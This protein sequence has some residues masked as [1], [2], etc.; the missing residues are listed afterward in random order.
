MEVFRS[1]AGA[2]AAGCVLS[3]LG[4]LGF[5][6]L[7]F[8]DRPG[9]EPHKQQGG[10]VALGGGIAVLLAVMAGLAAGGWRLPPGETGTRYLVVAMGAFALFVAGMIDDI[11]K[12]SPAAKVAIEAAVFLLVIIAGDVQ[13][14]LFV[15]NYAFS[16]VVTFMWMAMLTNAFNLID[17]HDGLA[18][19]VGAIGT[20]FLG[21]VC[22]MTGDTAAA[23]ALMALSGAMTGFVLVNFPPAHI[24]MGDAGTLPVGFLMAS[25]SILPSFYRAGIPG[26]HLAVLAPVFVFAVLLFDTSRVM[27]VRAMAGAN[28]FKADNRHFSHRLRNLGLSPTKVCCVHYLFA[29]VAAAPAVV[30]MEVGWLGAM[31]L[32]AQLFGTLVLILII[33]RAA[34]GKD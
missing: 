6:R 3:L 17:N 21:L 15:P 4:W 27:L 33:E 34:G 2:A 24:Y 20:F 19:G 7:G 30:L 28:P 5:R 14:T 11:R 23:A 25:M 13:I 12:L 26:T 1:F 32:L 22:V 9:T 8:L 31:V 16:V 10:A 18:G 29:A